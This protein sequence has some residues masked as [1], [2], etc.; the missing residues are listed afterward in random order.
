MRAQTASGGAR[1]FEGQRLVIV[2]GG[3]GGH[4]YPGLAVA[5]AWRSGGGEVRYVGSETGFEARAV[6]AQGVDFVAIR[7]RRLKNAG[8]WERVR[9]LAGMP[10]SLWRA[11]R[12]LRTLAPDVVLGVG[13]YV[14]GPVVLAAAL[15]RRPCAIA[16]Q[17]A[18]PGL[19]N[20][21]LGR[22]VRRIYT[23]FPEAAEGLSVRKVRLLG[24]PVRADFL[25]QAQRPYT[26]PELPQRRRVLVL[27]GSQG[28]KA[29]NERLPAAFH[30]LRGEGWPELE[31][32]HQAGRGKEEAVRAAYDALG[33]PE[34]RVAAFIDDVPEA[35]LWADLVVARSGA[36]TVAEL[37]V[38]GR[39][40]LLIPFPF[41]ADDHQAAN[42]QA[43]VNAQAAR[44]V[45]EA[46]LS[47]EVLVQHLRELLEDPQR[48][49]QMAA[50]AKGVARPQ[51]AAEIA[52]DLLSLAQARRGERV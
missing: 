38:L 40:A 36:T 25:A 45:R 6:P 48:L 23:A 17:N 22:F 14:S 4:V 5:E 13:G 47:P 8:L 21:L 35:L 24:N 26:P 11:W 52:L 42:A 33:W 20:R 51:A 50:Q 29:L 3:T 49:A 43:L 30:T 2:G 34:A 31:V 41:A 10:V 39:P 19:T 32:W 37:A 46:A 7:A 12:L 15:S 44:M 18:K 28:A 9:T 16:E 27:G 1:P